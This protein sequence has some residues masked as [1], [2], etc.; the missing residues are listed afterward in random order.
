MVAP[1]GSTRL[2][3]HTLGHVTHFWL[4][5]TTRE[6]R[7]YLKYALAPPTESGSMATHRN[8]ENKMKDRYSAKGE[9]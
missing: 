7:L 1:S 3:T 6:I 2:L 8:E 4:Y 9:Q 5:F